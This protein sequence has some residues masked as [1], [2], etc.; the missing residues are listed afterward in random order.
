MKEAVSKFTVFF[1]NY[2]EY[3]VEAEDRH[4]ACLIAKQMI[5]YD[6]LFQGDEVFAITPA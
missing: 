1:G 6:P 4:E 3:T 5:E 2:G